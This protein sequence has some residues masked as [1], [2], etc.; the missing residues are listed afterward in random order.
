MRTVWLDEVFLVNFAADI[1]ALA[2]AG[3]LCALRIRVPKLLLGALLGALYACTSE[4]VRTVSS[5]PVKLAAGALMALCV[6]GGEEKLLRVS[7]VFCLVSASMAGIALGV[8]AALGETGVLSLRALVVTLALSLAALSAINGFRRRMTKGGI[9]EL[10][11]EYAGKKVSMTALADTGNALRDPVSGA[12]LPVV[13]SGKAA[14][15]FGEPAAS[16]LKNAHGAADCMER[17]FEAAPELRCRLVSYSAVG[18]ENGLLLAVRLD[19][20]SIDGQ[21]LAG[22]WVALSP[23][24]VSDSGEYSALVGGQ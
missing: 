7:A 5:L 3:R 21:R 14:E 12:E 20:A 2:G 1:I 23:T 4:I 8:S 22:G 18:V 15:L 19:G 10:T 24:K 16:A 17:L 11:L 6:Y 13:E 9:R